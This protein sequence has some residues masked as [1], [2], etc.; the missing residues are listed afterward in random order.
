MQGHMK[1]HHLLLTVH[2]CPQR[3]LR[4]LTRADRDT[5]P[6][7]YRSDTNKLTSLRLLSLRT[8]SGFEI[9]VCSSRRSRFHAGPGF[10]PPRV[11]G[12]TRTINPSS[13]LAEQELLGDLRTTTADEGSWID[14][15]VWPC[16]SNSI[17]PVVPDGVLVI[18]WTLTL[19]ATQSLYR[20]G[21]GSTVRACSDMGLGCWGPLCRGT[22]TVPIRQVRCSGLFP[23]PVP[24]Y[25]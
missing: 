10:L 11:A 22:P 20:Q 14:L 8:I 12:T 16:A 23:L 24:A 9:C 18:R 5:P 6:P 7:F 4:G 2:R 15:P 3:P 1:L 19:D 17:H 21:G 25:C 13:I